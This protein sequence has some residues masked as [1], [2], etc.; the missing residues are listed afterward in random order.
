[1][2]NKKLI[3]FLLIWTIVISS[4]SSAVENQG[5]PIVRTDQ[6]T[7]SFLVKKSDLIAIVTLSGGVKKDY[8][9]S[10]FHRP[11]EKVKGKINKLIKG[12]VEKNEFELLAEPTYTIPNSI[13]EYILLKNGDHL[14]FLSC[15]NTQCR[16]TTGRSLLD[17]QYNKVYPTW[18]DDHYKDAGP[19]GE[20]GSYGVNLEEVLSEISKEINKS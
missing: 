18:R 15:E 13:A 11:P 8:K 1:M 17:I 19:G 4:I 7:L 14:V 10:F 16:P 5:I 9:M 12:N 3:I 6:D 20:F 2:K